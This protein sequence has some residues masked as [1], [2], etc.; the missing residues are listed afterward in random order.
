MNREDRWRKL[1]VAVSLAAGFSLSLSNIALAQDDAEASDELRVLEE[2]TVTARKRVEN[3]Q[4]VALSVSA[5]G[6]QEIENNLI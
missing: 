1:G 5:A 3:I 4:D 2:V 6:K